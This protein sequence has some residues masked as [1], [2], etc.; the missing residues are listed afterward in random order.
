[1]FAATTSSY[2]AGAFCQANPVLA[3]QTAWKPAMPELK[4]AGIEGGD[5]RFTYLTGRSGQR[6]MFCLVTRTQAALYGD[7]IFAVAPPCRRSAD[8]V[9]A[10]LPDGLRDA[11][12]VFVHLPDGPSVDAILNDL[13]VGD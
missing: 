2:K 9:A 3:E 10:R 1:M 11:D 7:C 13:A 12:R 8:R 6:Y 4:P 5:G